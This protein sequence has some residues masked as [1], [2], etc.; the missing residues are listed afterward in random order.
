MWRWAGVLSFV[1][2]V[3]SI[4]TSAV[5]GGDI[6]CNDRESLLI[7]TE[8][9]VPVDEEGEPIVGCS[10]LPADYVPV[11]LGTVAEVFANCTMNE[12]AVVQTICPVRIVEAVAEGKRYFIAV[13]WFDHVDVD[14]LDD[15]LAQEETFLPIGLP[16]DLA[17]CEVHRAT[18]GE[19]MLAAE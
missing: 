17:A 13:G 2:S 6:A 18:G 12:E 14:A 4:S 16:C 10:V 7:V 9:F 3:F 15:L 8:Q 5:A 19:T 11:T 1:L